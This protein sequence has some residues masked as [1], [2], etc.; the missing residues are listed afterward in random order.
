MPSISWLGVKNNQ[1]IRL[2]ASV[3]TLPGVE[4]SHTFQ[5]FVKATP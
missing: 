1:I 5:K 4:N 3:T 2:T